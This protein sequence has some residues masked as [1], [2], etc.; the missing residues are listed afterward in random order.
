MTSAFTYMTAIAAA[1]FAAVALTV[2]PAM[3]KSLPYD[4]IK[5]FEPVA[6]VG[7][8]SLVAVTNPA[9]PA[10]DIKGLIARAKAAPGKLKFASVGVGS[11]QHFAGELFLQTAGVNIQ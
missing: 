2:S 9:F 7:S 3:F 5:D 10:N 1:A 11:V 6:L 8:A 4:P